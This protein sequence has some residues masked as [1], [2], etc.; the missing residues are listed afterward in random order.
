MFENVDARENYLLTIET[1][2][3]YY[4]KLINHYYLKIIATDMKH[5]IIIK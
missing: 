4:Y 3:T 1:T 5:I 2:N